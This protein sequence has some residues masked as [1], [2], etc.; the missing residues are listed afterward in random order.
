[1]SFR[2]APKTGQSPL[3]QENLNESAGAGNAE[4]TGAN[5]QVAG[6]KGSAAPKKREANKDLKYNRP[7]GTTGF[8]TSTSTGKQREQAPEQK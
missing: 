3:G 8:E 1:M 5:A 7:A 4:L 6:T 2:E